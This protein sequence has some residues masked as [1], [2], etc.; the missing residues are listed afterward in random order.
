MLASACVRAKVS[1]D[2]PASK[3]TD[4]PTKGT[5]RSS[6][7]APEQDPGSACLWVNSRVVVVVAHT[8]STNLPTTNGRN[9]IQFQ[10]SH[11]ISYA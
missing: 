11:L 10:R 4:G 3:C 1:A 5:D 2:G 9:F 6:H 7:T 8:S